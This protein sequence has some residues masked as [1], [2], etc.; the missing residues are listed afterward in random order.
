MVLYA[1]V[2]SF[3]VFFI[4]SKKGCKLIIGGVDEQ[5]PVYIE[6]VDGTC[7]DW[8][9]IS[10]VVTSK[11]CEAAAQTLSQYNGNYPHYTNNKNQFGRVY[12]FNSGAPTVASGP[13]SSV[14][15]AGCFSPSDHNNNDPLDFV[16]VPRIAWGG[17]DKVMQ[18]FVII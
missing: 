14:D 8:A 6:R 15:P 3:D 7:K 12:S 5:I 2:V 9:N 13:A 11:D 18:N 10:S 1:D 4:C 17:E 16:K